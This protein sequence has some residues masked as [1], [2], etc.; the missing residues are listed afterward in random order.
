M[1]LLLNMALL[2]I[3]KQV[4]FVE[5]EEIIATLVEANLDNNVADWILGVG[6]TRHICEDKGLFQ[7]FEDS[8][9]EDTVYMGNSAAAEVHGKGKFLLK[10]TYGKT[11]ALNNVL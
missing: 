9:E 10:L 1:E 2:N 6:A 7:E 5:D 8:A 11:L 4:N 3:S